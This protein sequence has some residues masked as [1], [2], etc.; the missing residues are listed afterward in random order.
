MIKKEDL[1]E[2]GK[3][4]KTHALKGELNAILD[5]EED[6]LADGNPLMIEIEGIFV[7]FYAETVR[8]KGSTSFLVK[9]KGIDD[10]SAAEAMVNKAIYGRK[11]DLIN[12]F[13]SPEEEIMFDSD[14]I[15]YEVTDTHSGKIGKIVRIDDS[16]ANVLAVVDRG[17]GKPE[18][19]IPWNEDLIDEID[20][21]ARSIVVTLPAGIVDLNG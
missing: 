8:Q 15:G 21:D 19:F 14:L 10:V 7:P 3:F 9:L 18:V 4:Q 2:I 12:Y 17:E 6:Y 11:K 20:D 16:T 13:D 5:V 1:V